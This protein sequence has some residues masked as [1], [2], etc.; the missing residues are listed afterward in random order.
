[1]GGQRLR[2]AACRTNSRQ[3]SG[4]PALFSTYRAGRNA[5]VLA[6]YSPSGVDVNQLGW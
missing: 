6:Q 3:R 1:M 2:C 5:T 4:G